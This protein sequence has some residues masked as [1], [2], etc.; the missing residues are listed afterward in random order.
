MKVFMYLSIL[1]ITA[2][3]AFGFVDY[4]KAK[5]NG[6]LKK[7]YVDQEE[8]DKVPLTNAEEDTDILTDADKIVTLE[9]EATIKEADKKIVKYAKKSVGKTR[10]LAAKKIAPPPP[11]EL[12]IKNFG[13]S[14]L[15]PTTKVKS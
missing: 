1:L 9:K 7:V 5:Q 15:R 13:R 12:S 10:R 14:S 6:T 4:V 8:Q 2:G 3:A 11:P